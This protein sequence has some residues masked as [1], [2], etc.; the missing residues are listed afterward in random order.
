MYGNYYGTKKET[1]KEALNAGKP[2]LLNIDVDGAKN[3]RESFKDDP[4]V[5]VVSIFFKPPSLQELEKRLRKR[6]FK[7]VRAPEEAQAVEA[8]IQKR[9]AR[10]DYEIGCAGEFDAEISY[11]S[12][13]E[14]RQDIK[15]L[16]HLDEI[17]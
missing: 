14:G 1:I 3:I 16:L 12:P 2:V 7:S 8:N 6:E 9:L 15:K 10:A 17:V 11:Y 13:E 4:D 5:K